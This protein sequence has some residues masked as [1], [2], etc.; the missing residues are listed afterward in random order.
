MLLNFPH[1]TL[2]ASAKIQ[3]NN[4]NDAD[5]QIRNTFLA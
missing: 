3:I 5:N 2:I 1:F 4:R